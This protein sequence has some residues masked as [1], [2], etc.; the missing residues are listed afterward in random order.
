MKYKETTVADFKIYGET[1]GRKFKDEL[2]LEYNETT[3][4]DRQTFV[5]RLGDN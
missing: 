2:V 1:F 5:K 4:A 3:V